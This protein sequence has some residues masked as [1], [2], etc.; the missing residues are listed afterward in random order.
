MFGK[1]LWEAAAGS[2][3]ADKEEVSMKFDHKVLDILSKAAEDVAPTREECKRLLALGEATPEAFAVR[4]AAGAIVRGKNENA[5]YIYGQIG[6]EVEPCEANCSFCAFSKDYTGFGRVRMDD[7]SIAQRTHEFTDGGDM[8]GLCVMTMH[9]Y[10]KDFFLHA[11]DIAR[12]NAPSGTRIV[13]NIGDTDYEAFAE[14]KAAGLD[15]VYHVCRLGEGKYTKL[16]PK[17]RIRTMENAKK[18]G[19]D[20]LDTLE[21]I[22]PEHGAD[23][24]LDNIF[25]TIEMECL[26]AGAMKRTPVPGTPFENTGSI[27]DLRLAQ[28]LAIVA[29]AM[30]HL[31]R[32]PAILIHEPGPMGLVSGGNLISAETGVNPRDTAADTAAGR[33]LDVDACRRMLHEAGFTAL[34]RGDDTKVALTPEYI[35]AARR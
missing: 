30:L 12:A 13:S 1:A 6:V 32:Y 28:I 5:A 10:D 31:K 2:R 7:A 35:E 11:V 15:S 4:A 34:C 3:R 8:F 16:D 29:L 14:M 22:G 19:L 25:R 9:K 33:G 23:E 17:D 26:V 27:T 20:L 21:P 18:A 24:L